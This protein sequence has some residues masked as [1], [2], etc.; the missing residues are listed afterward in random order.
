[1]IL[2]DTSVWIE[3]LSGTWVERV[4]EDDLLQ[5]VTC[6]PILQEVLQG[7]RAGPLSDAFH[8]AFLALPRLSD[9]LPLSAFLQAAEIYRQGRRKGYTI[10]S[11]T[12]CLIA[13]IAVENRVPVWH[14]DRDFSVIAR[15][16]SLEAVE[17]L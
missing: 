10:R 3:L 14:K 4:S 5:F 17:R 11:S 15:Y 1:M 12:D 2:V 7:L 9:P 16:T 13:A 6:G 8:E